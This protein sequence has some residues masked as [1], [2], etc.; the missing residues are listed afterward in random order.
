M[1]DLAD[2]LEQPP[3]IRIRNELTSEKPRLTSAADIGG[4]EATTSDAEHGKIWLAIA[5]GD[6]L[7]ILCQDPVAKRNKA[8]PFVSLLGYYS[9]VDHRV[10][11][12]EAIEP[13]I[14]EQL[15]HYM[16]GDRSQCAVADARRTSRTE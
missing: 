14:H 11:K 3:L 15:L 12:S 1:Y 13:Q 7:G 6:R 2:N 8:R 5:Y 4:S 9:C 16:S 10:M